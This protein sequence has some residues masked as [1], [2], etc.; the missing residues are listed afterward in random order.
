MSI[1]IIYALYPTDRQDEHSIEIQ[2]NLASEFA[3]HRSWPTLASLTTAKSAAPSSRRVSSRIELR[4]WRICT[5]SSRSSQRRMLHGVGYKFQWLRGQDCTE[6]CTKPE[7]RAR[8]QT[9]VADE[10]KCPLVCKVEMS[11][12]SPYSTPFSPDPGGRSACKIRSGRVGRTS[13]ALALRRLTRQPV[14]ATALS[15]AVQSRPDRS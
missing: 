7:S 8:N 4:R 12:Y 11:D 13:S 6:T 3:A 14:A 15:P 9:I 2:V 5:G 10:L 1:V